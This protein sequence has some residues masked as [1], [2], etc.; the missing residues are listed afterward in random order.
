MPRV[1]PLMELYNRTNLEEKLFHI[2]RY[3]GIE[4][5][6]QTSILFWN[7]PEIILI[8]TNG[9]TKGVIEVKGGADPSG[10]LEQYEAA[11]KSFKNTREDAPEA[12]TILIA[13]G[14]T[15]EVRE[16]INSDD[17]IDNFFDLTEVINEK[18]QHS[19]FIELVF[20]TL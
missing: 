15:D 20:S 19:G 13:G 8:G 12:K 2:R 14:I 10:A 9:S 6:T 11:K 16:H 5:N 7:K 3:R 18:K 17:T 1:G 4:L